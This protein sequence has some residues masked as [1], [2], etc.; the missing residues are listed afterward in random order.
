MHQRCATRI[1][2]PRR[3]DSLITRSITYAAVLRRDAP[4]LNAVAAHPQNVSGIVGIAN[5]A[6]RAAAAPD[7]HRLQPDSRAQTLE[8]SCRVRENRFRSARHVVGRNTHPR[9]QR[10]LR[11]PLPTRRVLRSGR[12]KS[13][14]RRHDRDNCTQAHPQNSNRCCENEYSSINASKVRGQSRYL[15][16]GLTL[17]PGNYSLPR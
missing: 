7:N 6:S 2:Q 12:S 4:L 3:N 10:K 5:A 8:R 11:A 15:N 9:S 13:E 14:Q 17:P 16:E 1:T